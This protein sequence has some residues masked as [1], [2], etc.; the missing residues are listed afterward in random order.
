MTQLLS[1]R[2]TK[3]AISLRL[4]DQSPAAACKRL[5]F[6]HIFSYILL[7]AVAIIALVL[8]SMLS[9]IEIKKRMHNP[10]RFIR[11]KPMILLCCS[12]YL[13]GK[14]FSE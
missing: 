3:M 7:A 8:I 9:S 14:I 4:K 1:Q 13:L 10:A 11:V 5:F 2:S 12:L 6:S